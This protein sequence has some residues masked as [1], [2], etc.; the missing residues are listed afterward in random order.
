MMTKDRIMSNL[1][2]KVWSR[3]IV[4][5]IVLALLL[6]VP[7][8]T[9]EYWQAW[10]YLVVFFAS[11]VA[12]TIYLMNKDPA[13]LMRRMKAGPTAEREKTQK[14]IMFF[15]MVSFVTIFLVSAL[16]Y[17]F[18]WSPVPLAVVIGGDIVV[19]LGFFITFLVVKENTFA[20]A[21][22]EITKDQSVISTGPYAIVRHP[23]YSGG[24]LIVLGT[25]LA[26]GSLWGFL[27]FIPTSI[28]IVWRLLDE[29]KFLAKNLAGYDEYR[30]K[31]RYRLV[32]HVW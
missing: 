29:E 28:W 25:P 31:I 20:S 10:V 2:T 14:I 30:A 12:V 5:A 16:D 7:A 32:P 18:M 21:T 22:I 15:A 6:F 13:L 27:T 8:G 24:L 9:I 4:F 11:S 19:A 17:R 3:S 1:N 26:L 23:M